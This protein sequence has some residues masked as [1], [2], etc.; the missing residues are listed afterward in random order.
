MDD[1]RAQGF[2]EQQVQQR[3]AELQ[4]EEIQELYIIRSE[5]KLKQWTM[6]GTIPFCYLENGMDDKHIWYNFHTRI[7]YAIND[8]LNIY[9]YSYPTDYHQPCQHLRQP[10]YL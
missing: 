2:D 8:F 9:L 3:E 1:L 5:K 6:N 4:L 10:H 7:K